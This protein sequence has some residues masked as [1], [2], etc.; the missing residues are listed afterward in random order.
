M[1]VLSTGVVPNTVDHKIPF[2]IQY[3]NSILEITEEDIELTPMTSDFIKSINVIDNQGMVSVALANSSPIEMDLPG[4]LVKLPFKV[5][6]KVSSGDIS[7][8]IFNEATLTFQS[9][10]LAPISPLTEDAELVV[11][12][13]ITLGDVD[14]NGVFDLIDAIL[15]LKVL[16]EMYEEFTPFQELLADANDDG[17]IEVD[18]ALFVLDEVV[19]NKSSKAFN[20]S[21]SFL[22][23]AS[24]TTVDVNLNMS[25]IQG[26][27]GQT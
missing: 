4:T 18:D 22:T 8:L 21:G 6:K 24:T 20:N 27:V 26:E 2:K 16:V 19:L 10:P 5:K 13:G 15:I 9:D 11:V 25:I 14:Q 1:A 7:Y 23:S 12:D 17:F 3:D